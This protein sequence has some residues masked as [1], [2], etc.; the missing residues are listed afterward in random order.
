MTSD[1]AGLPIDR[2]VGSEEVSD[3][4]LSAD[5]TLPTW[6]NDVPIAVNSAEDRV[7]G[8]EPTPISGDDLP[9]FT[10]INEP[11]SWVVDD[12]VGG[13]EQT[14]EVWLGD[15]KRE[16]KISPASRLRIFLTVG[17]LDGVYIYDKTG[18]NPEIPVYDSK[19]DGLSSVGAG[20][21]VPPKKNY[22]GSWTHFKIVGDPSSKQ[23]IEAQAYSDVP[24][25]Q[26]K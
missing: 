25:T 3:E 1:I 23:H 5:L 26:I 17:V 14:Q 7:A 20:H 21:W 18:N 15:W 8:E 22:V 16:G 2:E 24:V 4:P 19:E 10:I 12:A 6:S 13:L 11:G 9:Y